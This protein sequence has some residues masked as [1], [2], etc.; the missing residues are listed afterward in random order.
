M[1]KQLAL[2][3]IVA[4]SL[5]V[6]PA[7]TFAATDLG[8]FTQEELS[9]AEF[10]E[11]MGP[12]LRDEGIEAY[13]IRYHEDFTHWVLD[14]PENRIATKENAVNAYAK[15]HEAGHKITCAHVEP[16]TVDIR[17]DTAIARLIYE[18][19][20]SYADGKAE[21]NAWR[22]VGVFERYGDTW[23]ALSTNMA[24]LTT[25]ESESAGPAAY[26]MTCPTA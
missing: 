5:A 1:I 17:G 14:D 10:W 20:D 16:V 26:T 21:T 24:A 12:T 18:Q 19:T 25:I 11:Q 6:A 4:P 15:Y 2:A 9:V 8:Q 3:L 13:A 23:Q 7:P 22:M